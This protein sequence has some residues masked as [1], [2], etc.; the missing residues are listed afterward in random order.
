MSVFG[1]ISEHL[2]IAVEADTPIVVQL[3]EQ[4][5]WL[6]ASGMVSEGDTLPSIRGL[7]DQLGVH[8]H[9]V[10]EAYHRLE[11]TGLVS[12][13]T[14]TG[15]TVLRFAAGA[16]SGQ[17]VDPRSFLIGILLPAP[18]PAYNR[19]IEGIHKKTAGS[20]LLPIITYNNDNPFLAKR[21]LHQLI[22]KK[23]DGLIVVSM[24]DIRL[25]DDGF[26]QKGLPPVVH[27]DAPKIKVNSVNPDSQGAAKKLTEH[28]IGHGYE[29][30]A[31][32]T[33]PTDWESVEP[34]LRGYKRALKD[35]EKVFDAGLVVEAHD[36][37]PE[38]G[39]EAGLELLS[40]GAGVDA[41]LAGDDQLA[42]GAIRAL[43]ESGFAIPED[44]AL[45]AYG[46]YDLAAIT[47]PPL[48]TAHLP[49]YEMGV[50]AVER[51]QALF[52]GEAEEHAP[53]LLDCPLVI[54]RSCGCGDC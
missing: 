14:R 48:T 21:N 53:L 20:V 27:V 10:R 23:V 8:M 41:I 49:A 51:L 9:T 50:Q 19:F 54:R 28:L 2:R 3:T 17:E 52:G 40:R 39:A 32:V 35:K 24:G 38:S 46:D 43:K 29:R 1:E 42:I 16:L 25:V 34:V 26:D 6:I 33:A 31:L 4:L 47:E 15:T 18:S 36:F 44:I 45:A 7:A 22:A 12:I 13:R 30:V 37:L 5:T 11:G